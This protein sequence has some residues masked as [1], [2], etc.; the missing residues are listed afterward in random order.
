MADR[1]DY[2][3]LVPAAFIT[4]AVAAWDL[5]APRAGYPT[6]SYVVWETSKH[7]VVGPLFVGVWAGLTWHLF[8]TDGR[9]KARHI[10]PV[11]RPVSSTEILQ[12]VE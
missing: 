8:A 10:H 5:V 2:R 1:F 11:L 7:P 3:M 6:A 4:A 9:T 12:V